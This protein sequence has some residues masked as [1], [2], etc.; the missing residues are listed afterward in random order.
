MGFCATVLVPA[1]KEYRGSGDIT[2]LILISAL[3]RVNRSNSY[4][5]RFSPGKEPR[6]PLNRRLG[7]P[8]SQSGL[9]AEEKNP[10]HQQELDVGS[11]ILD[12]CHYTDLANSAPSSI[13]VF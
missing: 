2:S 5:G 11:P 9:F 8:K 7:E 3:D 13:W 10:F 1:M 6:S 4:P 12:S